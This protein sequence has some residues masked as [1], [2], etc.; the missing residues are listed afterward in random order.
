MQEGKQTRSNYRIETVGKDV[1]QHLPASSCRKQLPMEP[2]ITNKVALGKSPFEILQEE[3]ETDKA[4]TETDDP[5]SRNG[6]KLTT[7]KGDASSTVRP[8][9]KSSANHSA[10]GFKIGQPRNIRSNSCPADVTEDGE[11]L[12][13]FVESYESENRIREIKRRC[14]EPAAD[15]FNSTRVHLPTRTN[16]NDF[17]GGCID[18]VNFV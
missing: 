8:L 13:S 7:M 17:T 15:D 16:G 12:V 6:V 3:C 10:E 18:N 2:E 11:V 4:G 1:A 9:V 5:I 14:K